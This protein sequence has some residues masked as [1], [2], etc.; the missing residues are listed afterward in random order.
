MGLHHVLKFLFFQRQV[1]HLLVRCLNFELFIH[2]TVHIVLDHPLSFFLEVHFT[3]VSLRLS[4]PFA[5]SRL[6]CPLSILLNIFFDHSLLV[7]LTLCR[8]FL[9]GRSL[10]N[11]DHFM[12]Y[13][14]Y[15]PI[16]PGILLQISRYS[17]TVKG[18][19]CGK[20][21]FKRK[22]NRHKKAH[23]NKFIILV[24]YK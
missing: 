24:H 20:I 23:L 10:S 16:K 7:V 14:R 4:E 11:T 21:F 12:S 15:H 9:S 3:S 13:R 6:V 1:S 19:I 8:P 5:F 18:E 17:V 22:W 2:S